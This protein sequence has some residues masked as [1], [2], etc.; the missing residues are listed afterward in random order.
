MS[1]TAELQELAATVR[2]VLAKHGDRDALRRAI[3]GDLGYDERLWTLLCEQ[4]GVAALAIPE[5]YGGVGAG[6]AAALVVVEELGRTLHAP[7][8]LGSAVLGVQAVLL[9]G[10]TEA[11]ARLLPEVAEGGRTLA[12]CWATERGWDGYG[13]QV[14][15]GNLTGTAHYVLDGAIADTLIVP[16]SDGLYEIDAAAP[17]VARTV[18]PTMDPTRRLAEITFT[19]APA[20]ALGGEPAAATARLREI[21]WAALAAEQVGAADQCLQETVEYTKSRVQFGRAIGSFQALKHRMADMYVLVESARSAA[22]A[23]IADLS[24]TTS[25]GRTSGAVVAPLP[26]PDSALD[27]AAARIHCSDAYSKVVGEMVQ[28][29]GG[30][31]ITWEHEAHLYFKRAHADTQLFGAPTHPLAR[32]A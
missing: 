17:E 13:I 5:E 25:A 2:A 28:M 4:V 6:L 31:A 26:R 10:N 29:H 30:I 9:S 20:R 32:P 16:T 15:S 12:L 23:A 14:E 1:S 19:A 11:C 8:M 24:E 27:L 21:A 18:A 7:P 22:Y 3:D